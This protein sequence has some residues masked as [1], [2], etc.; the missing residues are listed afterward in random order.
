MEIKKYLVKTER[1]VVLLAYFQNVTLSKENYLSP[2]QFQEA[3]LALVTV[4]GQEFGVTVII[5]K[6]KD[7]T[8]RANF[9]K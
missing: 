3:Y 6:P 8:V 9:L 1:S 4:G 7:K 5:W 2:V